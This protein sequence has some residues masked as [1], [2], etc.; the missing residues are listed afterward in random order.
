MEDV[1]IMYKV[2]TWWHKWQKQ[3]KSG[4]KCDRCVYCNHSSMLGP[5]KQG[6]GNIKYVHI[7]HSSWVFSTWHIHSPLYI[8]Y[9]RKCR[10]V[11]YGEKTHS[12]NHAWPFLTSTVWA[13]HI[14]S[15][16]SHSGNLHKRPIPRDFPGGPVDKNLP[17]NSG[18]R[19]SIPA[20]GRFPMLQGS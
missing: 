9:I 17:A 14:M 8:Q 12:K 5:G 19:G 4:E 13:G 10:C 2:E 6:H 18:D 7:F 20:L 16:M 11:A 15:V 1:L 3:V